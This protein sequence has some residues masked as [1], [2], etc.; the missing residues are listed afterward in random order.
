MS[1][2]ATRKKVSVKRHLSQTV[3]KVHKTRI[4]NSEEKLKEARERQR[5][6][7]NKVS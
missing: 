4:V 1:I 7:R 5:W 6:V 2:P 3:T